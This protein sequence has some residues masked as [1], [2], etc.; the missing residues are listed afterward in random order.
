MDILLLIVISVVTLALLFDF[1][2]GFHDAAN[3]VATV[4]ATRAMPARWAVWFSAA[5]NFAAY[6]FVGT[7]VANTVA[8]TVKPGHV[9]VAVV[10]A[11]LFA[12]IAWNFLT[13]HFGM[14]SSSSHAIIGGLVGAGVAA[15]GVSAVSWGSVWKTVA[16]IVASPA[17]A[18]TVAAVATWLV[19]GIQRVT[20]LSDDAK[21]F[22][23]LQ[24]LSAAAVSFGHG[25]NDAQKTMGVIAALLAGAGYLDVTAGS[26]SL[27][28][29]EWA[30]LASYA[31]IAVG[32]AW[33][34]WKIIDTMGNRLTKLSART[35]VSANIGA[36]TAIFGATALGVPI[37]TT[38][39]AASSV[40][41][42]GTASGQGAN[43]AVII[44]M[45]TAWVA[46]IPATAAVSWV[47]YEATALPGFASVVAVGVLLVLLLCGIAW[48]TMQAMSA[49]ELEAEVQATAGEDT[50]SGP[51]LAACPEPTTVELSSV[52]SESRAVA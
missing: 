9:T 20:R 5:C 11:A 47:V 31:A 17:V 50:A 52:E 51:D 34:G 19:M 12:A 18:L 28:V 4:V 41:G 30:A 15:G 14:P 45:V 36:T 42:A 13:W 38:H 10:F 7:A 32:T 26:S 29:P 39:A 33:G 24:L 35:G 8:K 37:S 43:R 6:F 49:H 44:Q 25:A 2:N 22:K 48:T 46:T 40:I 16:A 1:S 21:P 23:Y 3:S 27:P